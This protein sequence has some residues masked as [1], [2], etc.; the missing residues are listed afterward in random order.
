MK[1]EWKVSKGN[2]SVLIMVPFMMEDKEYR[3][4]LKLLTM[5]FMQERNFTDLDK[6]MKPLGE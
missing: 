4:K 2:S 1:D 5:D 3:K 6:L